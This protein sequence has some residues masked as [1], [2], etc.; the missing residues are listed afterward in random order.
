MMADD[1]KTLREAA[2]AMDGVRGAIG[3]QPLPSLGQWN[4]EVGDP[5]RVDDAAKS[6]QERPLKPWPNDAVT[7][8]ALPPFRVQQ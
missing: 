5:R 4:F 2:I 7:K 3:G 6:M 1:L 8:E